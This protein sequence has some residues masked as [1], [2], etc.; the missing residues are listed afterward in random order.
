MSFIYSE[1]SNDPITSIVPHPVINDLFLASHDTY[2]TTI[3]LDDIEHPSINPFS[4]DDN[5]IS[6]LFIHNQQ[7]F[8]LSDKGI[9]FSLNSFTEN[10]FKNNQILNEPNLKKIDFFSFHGENFCAFLRLKSEKI[11]FVSLS[12][13]RNF[14][15]KF[16]HEIID[17]MILSEEIFILTE[18]KLQIYKILLKN[19]EKNLVS[20]NISLQNI[21]KKLQLS[22]IKDSF[23]IFYEN[24]LEIYDLK[25]Q[26]I[27]KIDKKFEFFELFNSGKF[28]G[29]SE[30]STI[31]SL[32]ENLEFEKNLKI[33][34]KISTA[35][36]LG[37]KLILGTFS[38]KILEISDLFS[39]K[40]PQKSKKMNEEYEDLVEA[41]AQNLD[42][43]KLYADSLS[44]RILLKSLAD[45]LNC[46]KNSVEILQ[47]VSQIFEEKSIFEEKQ[48]S[49][50]NE[51][52]NLRNSLKS[53]KIKQ[54][55][56]E[57]FEEKI[58]SLES[59][60]RELSQKID[61]KSQKSR[62]LFEKLSEISPK[63]NSLE[64]S[65]EN[66]LE[67]YSEL[68]FLILENSEKLKKLKN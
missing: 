25:Y 11:F 62:F 7:L 31:F 18:K 55:Y 14:S 4:C 41:Y 35:K 46:E 2:I 61:E 29:I 56:Q 23:A 39:K 16:D 64:E 50:N 43:K 47:K 12:S 44:Y 40:K 66:I 52:V 9:V 27:S 17:F 53:L 6:S 5:H 49:S 30:N 21:P 60:N 20:Y 42:S 24:F 32:S 54:N 67:K 48:I 33:S 22:L 13:G 63:S 57:N 37:Q 28:L 58:K 59:K 15:M 68:Q 34:E 1:I 45:I 19:S 10:I 51:I 26:K 65:V 3:R 8:A 38:G 36:I